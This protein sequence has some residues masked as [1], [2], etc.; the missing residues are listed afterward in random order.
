MSPDKRTR[1]YLTAAVMGLVSTVLLTLAATLE[2]PDFVTGLCVGVL[3][4]SL[5]LL[6]LRRFRD[7]YIEQLWN[8]GTSLAF[9][10]VVV[11]F[12]FSPF[13]EGV[14]DGLIDANH[15]PAIATE[16][17]GLVAVLAFFVGFHIKWLRSSL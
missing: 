16:A 14:F 17:I 4:A 10:A 5:V 15:E 8:S 1:L 12:I 2:W 6:L 11:L 9:S 7:E 3:L 13:L